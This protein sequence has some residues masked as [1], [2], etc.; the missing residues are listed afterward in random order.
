MDPRQFAFTPNSGLG[1]DCALTLISHKLL[2]W[3]DQPG[4]VRIVLLDFRKAF[5]LVLRSR[6]LS[7]LASFGIPREIL[8]WI[9]NY[10]DERQQC[11]TLNG[12]RSSWKTISSGV[13]QG[14]VLGP[15]LFFRRN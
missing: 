8:W 15:L 1:T 4:A 11:V 9:F 3:L 12:Q 14:S 5:D 13:P 7:A 10:L 6:I 2:A